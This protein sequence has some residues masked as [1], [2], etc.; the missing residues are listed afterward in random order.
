MTQLYIL[1]SILANGFLVYLIFRYNALLF[2]EMRAGSNVTWGAYLIFFA[3]TTLLH[4]AK[5]EYMT[6]WGIQALL[7][8]CLTF[9]YQA[10][11]LRRILSVVLLYGIQMAV[12]MGLIALSGHYDLRLYN[13]PLF[14]TI[15]GFLLF[16]SIIFLL[17]VAFECL[18]RLFHTRENLW[19][20]WISTITVPAAL[21][22]L[23]TFA[24][25]ADERDLDLAFFASLFILLI[26]TAALLYLYDKKTC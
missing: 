24:F 10:K 6:L 23:L 11:A 25:L 22:Y 8:L 2:K 21:L 19:L 15:A 9:V 26:L 3:V 20:Y 13:P 14:S 18:R 7:C 4:F 1:S 5:V 16:D 17:L 12:D